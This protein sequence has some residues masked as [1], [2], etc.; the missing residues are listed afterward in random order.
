V[1]RQSAVEGEH[2]KTK[3]KKK[4]RKQ[5]KGVVKGE[6]YNYKGKRVQKK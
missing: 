3:H 2:N 5:G 1:T 6:K 4:N